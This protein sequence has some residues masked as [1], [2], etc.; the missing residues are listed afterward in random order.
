MPRVHHLFDETYKE[1]AQKNFYLKYP[2]LKNKKILLY[3]PTFRGNIYKGFKAVDFDSKSLYVF[4][5]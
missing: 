1:E 2:K 4:A 5:G 3:A